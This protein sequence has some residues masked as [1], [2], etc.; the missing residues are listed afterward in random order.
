MKTT[1]TSIGEPLTNEQLFAVAP[2]IFA[3][4]PHKSRSEKYS[5]IPTITVLDGLRK[6]GFLP[7]SVAQ[8]KSRIEGKSEFTKHMIRFRPVNDNQ[9]KKIGDEINEI[10]MVNSHDGTSSYQMMSGVFRLVC[11]NGL[12]RG[13]IANDI[14]VRHNGNNLVDGVIEAAYS[15]V[16][17]FPI[18]NTK[19]AEMKQIELSEPEQEVFA[20]AALSLKYD[21]KA[22]ITGTDLL[23]RRRYE[24]DTNNLWTKFN[25]V[26]ENLI[27]GGQRGYSATLKKL[28]TRPVNSIDNSI[29]LN[30]ALWI[31]AD[32]MIELK[33][34]KVPVVSL[35]QDAS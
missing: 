13:D 22:P 30:K 4:A 18:I 23:K 14:R 6:E 26:Q 7:Y 5:F 12:V 25:V 15:I 27:K 35:S 20:T 11:L 34:S 3:P 28:K 24:D 19:I 31:L 8:S 21:E 10:V 17:E 2:S 9:S 33:N 32:K 1:Y 29:R 16:E